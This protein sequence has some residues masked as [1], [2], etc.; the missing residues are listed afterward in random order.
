MRC[1]RCNETGTRVI[2]SRDLEA[3]ST[4]RRRRECEACSYRFTTYERPEGA[5]LSVIKRDGS[6]QDFDRT[7]L[8]GGLLRALEKRPV[9]IARA[10]QAV[11][12]IESLLRARGQP[13]VTSKEVGRL[14]TEALRDI[15]QLAYIRFASV[16]HSYEDISTLKREVDRLMK[17]RT[18]AEERTE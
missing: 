17:Q 18:V 4:I 5:R 16:Y 9:T 8:L 12:D 10:E 7:K 3:G 14:A 13:E 15:D 2:D 6:R 11:D 1:P